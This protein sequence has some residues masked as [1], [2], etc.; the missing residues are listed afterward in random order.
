MSTRLLAEEVHRADDV[1]ELRAL[2]Q[3]GDLLLAAGDEVDLE[4]EQQIGLLAHGRA[5]GVEVVVG[6][7]LPERVAPDASAWVKR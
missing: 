4:P 5:V 3:L 2:H 7:A 6:E 1:V